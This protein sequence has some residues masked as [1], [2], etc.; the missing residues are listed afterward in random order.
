M[1]IQSIEGFELPSATRQLCGIL[2]VLC[3]MHVLISATGHMRHV[4]PTLRKLR[5][6]D[7]FV[8]SRF[9]EMF[10]V[11]RPRHMT[12]MQ[13]VLL[14]THSKLHM[15]FRDAPCTGFQGVVV[16]SPEG[17]DV[18][19]NLSFGIS[20]L[21][22]VQDY[23]L[24]SADFAA[25]D[26]T[27]EMLFLVEAKSA[28]MSASRNLNARLQS[29]K[30]A[31]EEQAFTDTLTGLK[32]RRAIGSILSQ[33]AVQESGFA[34]MQLDLDYFKSVNDGLGHAAGDHVLRCVAQI[35]TEETRETDEVVRMG[36]DEFVLIF[37]DAVTRRKLTSIATR[38]IERINEP[39]QIDGNKSQISA[40]IGITHRHGRGSSDFNMILAEADQ[41]LYNCK[42]NGRG[43]FEFYDVAD[44]DVDS[45]DVRLGSINDETKKSGSP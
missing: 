41:A 16:P 24:T 44:K 25:T 33:I 35:L 26:M 1:S 40:S 39:I 23:R 10:E 30:V 38:I 45:R 3:P 36:G 20:V 43:Q 12:T 11:H 8:G 19:L 2:D 22:A 6:D 37:R 21:D 7:E 34:L 15:R 9:L 13:Q 31:A 42:R 17:Q 5:P 28:A 27:V 4:G 29:A 14:S 32:N 18:I